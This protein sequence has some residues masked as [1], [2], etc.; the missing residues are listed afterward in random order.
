MK[1]HCLMI[2]L[3]Y[4]VLI[5]YCCFSYIKVRLIINLVKDNKTKLN[6]TLYFENLKR[7]VNNQPPEPQQYINSPT[8]SELR[9]QRTN[10]PSGLHIPS[11]G[12]S[13]CQRT[14]YFIFCL[15]ILLP[16]TL[17]LISLHLTALQ[18][19]DYW[20]FINTYKRYYSPYTNG[21]KCQEVIEFEL[22]F[23]GW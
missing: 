14:K 7:K 19:F 12:N 11:R 10:Q 21:P 8:N 1:W 22:L 16:F 15:L 2:H 20:Y 3:H 13:K 5:F 6:K 23:Q 17:I 4:K 9:S 18:I